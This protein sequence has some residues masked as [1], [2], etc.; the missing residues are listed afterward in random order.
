MGLPIRP[1]GA[2]GKLGR[3]GFLVLRSGGFGGK[4]RPALHESGSS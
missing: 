2:K 3:R 1:R 4:L